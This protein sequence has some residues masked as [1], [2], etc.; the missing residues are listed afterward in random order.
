MKELRA[1]ETGEKLT[2]KQ[3][4]LA[5]CADCMG[6]YADGKEDCLT[7]RCPLYSFMPYGSIWRHREK[8]IIA[9]TSMKGLSQR[10]KRV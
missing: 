8:K 2:L 5:K 1:F 4:I 6:K 3:S 7:P 10:I 9:E